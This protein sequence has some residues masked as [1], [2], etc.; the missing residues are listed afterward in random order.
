MSTHGGYSFP[1]PNTLFGRVHRVS[2]SPFLRSDGSSLRSC[3]PVPRPGHSSPTHRFIT[4]AWACTVHRMQGLTVER[5][6]VK[7]DE[8]FFAPGQAYVALSRVKSLSNVHLLSFNP[9]CL[10]HSRTVVNI[11]DHA[12]ASGKLKVIPKVNLVND[13]ANNICEIILNVEEDEEL[14]EMG[15]QLHHSSESNNSKVM[16]NSLETICKQM[17]SLRKEISY[18]FFNPVIQ[19]ENIK[20][21][22]DTFKPVF[23]KFLQFARSSTPVTATENHVID[24]HVNS[25]LHPAML[26]EYAPVV[27]TG[28]GNCLWNAVSTCL[29][30]DERLRLMLRFLTVYIMWENKAYFMDTIRNDTIHEGSV[31]QC[32]DHHL[33]IARNDRAWGNEYHMLALSIALQRDVFSYTAFSWEK[34]RW[35]ISKKSKI[36]TLA[37]AFKVKRK[38]TEGQL[39][40][41]P[42][43][44]LK[45]PNYGGEPI[46]VHFDAHRKHFTAIVPK[47][48]EIIIIR[49]HTNLFLTSMAK[50]TKEESQ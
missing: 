1:G 12:Q 9:K 14:Q 50:M 8:T 41:C 26:S 22:F 3:V 27:T 18:N 11:M 21:C 7:L 36:E 33:R 44:H 19:G 4:L 45:L 2:R 29:F 20:N 17:L 47:K 49:P 48:K 25:K 42:P 10:L 30:G 31:D 34:G 5:A 40:F 23:S 43:Q 28:D 35:F 38:G 16:S 13:T 32:F 15:N 37:N 39:I 6:H 24:Q 46:C